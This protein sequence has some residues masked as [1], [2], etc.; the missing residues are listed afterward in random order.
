MK[1]LEKLLKDKPTARK[2]DLSIHQIE[3][4][5][6]LIEILYRFKNLAELNLS[7]NRLESLPVDMS[8]LKKIT[9]LDISSNLF[10]NVPN[11][12]KSP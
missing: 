2:I 1:Y 10:K 3:E 9:T 4:I 7:C 6:S 11:F 12:L 8:I 5:D